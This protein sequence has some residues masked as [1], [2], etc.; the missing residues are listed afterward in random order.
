MNYDVFRVGWWEQ[1]LFLALQSSEDYFLWPCQKSL[2]ARQ[3]PHSHLWSVFSHGLAGPSASVRRCPCARDLSPAL[4][5]VNRNHRG[6]RDL[7]GWYPSWMGSTCVS[8]PRARLEASPAPQAVSRGSHRT[9]PASF[10]SHLSGTT[11]L[12]CWQLKSWKLL[13]HVFCSFCFVLVFL[14]IF[15][16]S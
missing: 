16:E 5:L 1:E 15:G 7:P 8:S 2:Q 10:V 12:K 3:A 6:L 14:A 11:I 4:S 9:Q 13:F